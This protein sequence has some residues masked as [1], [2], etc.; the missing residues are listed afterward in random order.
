[1]I[2]SIARL[3]HHHD[4]IRRAGSTSWNTGAE[5]LFGYTEA[6]IVG[7]PVDVAVHA[8]GSRDRRAAT[9]DATARARRPRRPTS[10]GTC[11][12]TAAAS[13]AAASWRRWPTAAHEGYVKIARDLTGAEP[14]RGAQQALLRAQATA[15]S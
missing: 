1:M 13:T 10:A 4:S 3:R 7:Q 11:A 6:E 2:E 5:R 9:R 15:P 12:R 14:L 8:G